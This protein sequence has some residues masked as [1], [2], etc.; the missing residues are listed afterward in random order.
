MRGFSNQIDYGPVIF[1]ALNV[2]KRQIN[3]LASALSATKQYGQQWLVACA[4]E[5]DD[6]RA[7]RRVVGDGDRSG[8]CSRGRRGKGNADGAVCPRRDGSSAGIGLRIVS[9]GHDVGNAQRG[10]PGVIQRHCLRRAGGADQLARESQARRGKA[11][12][13]APAAQGFVRRQDIHRR[14]GGT[15]SRMVVLRRGVA[16]HF[17]GGVRVLVIGRP[18]GV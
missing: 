18:L 9:A 8:P 6:V 2:V 5:T 10:I 16:E 1:A 11:H 17:V 15:K 3:Q 13:C 4:G 14:D 7:A 12:A